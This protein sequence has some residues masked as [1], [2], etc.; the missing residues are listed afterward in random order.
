MQDWFKLLILWFIIFGCKSSHHLNPLI[1]HHS[2]SLT[3][4][5]ENTEPQLPSMP[6]TVRSAL[7]STQKNNKDESKSSNK[8]PIDKKNENEC[9]EYWIYG[10]FFTLILIIFGIF[11]FED[12]KQ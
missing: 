3:E 9:S 4:D 10:A 2:Q 1:S 12:L 8:L 6:M 7:T 5:R 11:F